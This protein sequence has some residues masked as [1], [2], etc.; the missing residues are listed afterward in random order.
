MGL[1]PLRLH[2]YSAQMQIKLMEVTIPCRRYP[3]TRFFYSRVLCMPVGKEGE[4]HAF[5]DT[6]G[7][8]RLALVDA[9]QASPLTLPTGR[10]PYLNLACDDLNALKVR[11]EQA[12]VRVEAEQSDQYGRNITIRDPEGNTVNVYQDGSFS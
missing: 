5:L 11:L 1:A 9:N 3:Q 2:L 4:H 8:W 10:G 6:G 12:K 7:S